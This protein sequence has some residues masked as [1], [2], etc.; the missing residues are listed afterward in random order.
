MARFTIPNPK[1]SKFIEPGIGEIFGNISMTKNI[2][3]ESNYGRIK[4]SERMYNVYDTD[5]DAQLLLPIAFLRSEQIKSV[6]NSNDF[7]ALVQS[8]MTTSAGYIFKCLSTNLTNWEQDAIANSPTDC[9]DNMVNFRLGTTSVT[10]VVRQADVAK[11][12]GGTWTK[13]WYSTLSGTVALSSINPHYIHRFQNLLLIPDGNVIHTVDENSVV[14]GNRII[15]PDGYVVSW[16]VS[17]NSTIYFG[18]YRIPHPDVIDTDDRNTAVFT[19]D[20]YSLSYLQ[21]IIVNDPIVLGGVIDRGVLHILDGAGVLSKHNGGSGVTEIARLPIANSNYRLCS[22]NGSLRSA[23]IPM[24]PNGISIIDGKIHVNIKS[25]D[26]DVTTNKRFIK[27]PSG[28]WCYDSKIGFYQK[29]SLSLYDGTTNDR[30]GES[31]IKAAGALFPTR[32]GK[33]HFLAGATIAKDDG[34]TFIN[35]IQLSKERSSV[36]NRGYFI[37]SK[38]NSQGALEFW[39]KCQLVIKMLKNS[40]DSAIIKYR[41]DDDF[42]YEDSLSNFFKITWTNTTTFTSTSSYLANVEVG[43]EIEILQGKG[44]GATAHVST[45]TLA[46]GTYTVVLDEAIPNVSGDASA[47]YTNFKKLG[48]ITLQNVA[49]NILLIARRSQFIQF[50]VELRGD[51]ESPEIDKLIIDSKTQTL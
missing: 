28:V 31:V 5:D 34:T 38:L 3:L 11:L 19:W 4:L 12:A 27:Q 8:G 47:G 45:I 6:G 22:V 37:T 14:N 35:T 7:M 13:T 39:Q 10:L 32:K 51:F 24:H 40:T 15:L 41:S 50:K 25:L 48:S 1:D 29:Y 9:A 21:K 42:K 17:D 30:W 36:T 26:V 33:G 18:T 43:D 16:I 49:N 2:D 20:G 46:T 44:A 23:Y